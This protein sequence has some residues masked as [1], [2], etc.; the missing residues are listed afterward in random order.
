MEAEQ[1]ENFPLPK[2]SILSYTKNIFTPIRMGEC[3]TA[4]WVALSGRR[5]VTK[6]VIENLHLLK[7]VVPEYEEYLNVYIEPLDLTESSLE[8]YLRLI[9]KSVIA[10]CNKNEISLR[11][12]RGESFD[13]EDLSYQKLLMLLTDLI[14]E[15]TIRSKKVVL[16]LGELDEL[17]FIDNTF[18]NNLESLLHKFEEKLYFVF[19]IK[20]LNLLHDRGNFGEDLY[21]NFLQNIIYM[22]ISD[23]H[24][25]YLIDRFASRLNTNFTDGEKNLLKST[26]DGHPYFLKVACSLLVKVKSL[27]ESA[28]FSELIRSNHELRAAAKMILGVQTK[29]GLEILKK[30][31]SGVVKELEGDDAK[32]LEK[33][34]LVKKNIDGSYSPFCDLFKDT[35]LERSLP[36][37]EERPL[38][39]EGLVY[40]QDEN[41]LL[42]KGVPTE[43][44]FTPQEY[45]ILTAF[46]KE[47]N[48]LMSRE[49]V[50]NILW[51]KDSYDKYSDWAIDQLISKLRRKLQ[52]LGVTGTNLITLRGRG[53]KIIV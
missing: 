2:D 11:D 25:D 15:I 3:V 33:L 22:P 40:N 29:K 38:N 45:Q 9:G 53:Y 16:F 43:E 48:K 32:I 14:G 51:G 49:N 47:P 24:S 10:A 37:I 31:T 20:D 39:G 13:N 21:E 41:V 19:L 7:A 26:S 52:K 5:L 27:G 23:K 34:G 44:K 6:F 30:V 42:F 12:I 17:T 36:E 8:G 4:V 35:I 46:L 28:D 1:Q 18:S 50:G